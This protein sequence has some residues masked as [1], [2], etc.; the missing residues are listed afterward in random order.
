MTPKVTFLRCIEYCVWDCLLDFVV[1]SDYLVYTDM[2]DDG[3]R[4]GLCLGSGGRNLVVSGLN[5]CQSH[6]VSVFR[7]AVV[8]TDQV[9][10]RRRW[11]GVSVARRMYSHR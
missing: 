4:F 7:C 5:A 8:L 1:N 11:C 2:G 9:T 10:H 6:G 3:G